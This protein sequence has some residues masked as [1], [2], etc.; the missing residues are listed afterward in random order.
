MLRCSWQFHVSSSLNSVPFQN[1]LWIRL[2]YHHC[3]Q[4]VGLT[5][6]SHLPPRFKEVS[7]LWLVSLSTYRAIMASGFSL[8]TM[9]KLTM[10]IKRE[11]SQLTTNMF[12]LQKKMP[13]A[14]VWVPSQLL[15]PIRLK[16]D[17]KLVLARG[18]GDW[19]EPGICWCSS[20]FCHCHAVPE[21]KEGTR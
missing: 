14:R 5:D 1:S 15:G 7:L 20:A 11:I 16:A 17:D 8:S 21:M 19:G 4:H 18:P 13:T 9:R 12:L 2:R 10:K 6:Q 3:A